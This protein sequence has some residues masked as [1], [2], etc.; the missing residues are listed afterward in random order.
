[1]LPTVDFPTLGWVAI[2]WI[3]AYLV[4]G[5]GDVEGEP[6]ELDDELATHLLWA[7]RLDKRTGRRVVFEDTFSRPKGRA[8]SEFAG[9]LVCFEA[10]GPA[11]FDGWGAEKDEHGNRIP[12]GRPIRSPFIRCLATEEGQ[13]G[14][15][16]DNVQM[17][18][19]RGGAADEF[20]GLEVNRGRTS[21]PGGG[22]IIPSTASSSSKDGGKET[23]CV[24]DETHLYVLLELRRMH[25]TVMRNLAKRKA[26]EPWMFN[27]TTMFQPGEG[28]VAEQAYNRWIKRDRAPLGKDGML[29]DHR[30]APMVKKWGDDRELKA[31]LAEGYGPFAKVLDLSRIVADIRNDDA[32]EAESRRYWLNQRARASGS[33]RANEHW[34]DREVDGELEDGEPVCLGF[35]GSRFHDA[36]GLVAV[37]EDGF[38][39]VLGLWEKQPEDGPEWE[40]PTSEVDAA[41]DAA[42]QRF[43]VVRF[44]PDPAWWQAEVD[45]WAARHGDAVS[46]WWTNRDSQMARA[47]GRFATGV[48]TGQLTHPGNPDLTRHIGNAREKK[49]RI[50]LEDGNELAYVLVKDRQGSPHKIDLAVCAVLAAEAHGDAIAAGEFAARRK[51]RRR[52]LHTF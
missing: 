27:T 12:I 29:F 25:R 38:V 26:A 43:D 52:T 48:R 33:W 41:V 35:D 7:Y 8:K 50:K 40:V 32:T 34:A 18:L 5:P 37:T 28:S 17:M 44:Y 21:L 51:K 30:E 47:V 23:F 42:F 24:A 19:T 31:A 46:K 49:V 9:M 39:D 1:M 11:R 22:V 4:H 16:Y 36:T 14:N 6:I 15:T 45:A 3:E 10:L 20:P 13:A 2:D